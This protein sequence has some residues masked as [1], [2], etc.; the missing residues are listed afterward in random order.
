MTRFNAVPF[1]LDEF[2]A[3]VQVDILQIFVALATADEEHPRAL[4]TALV[5]CEATLHD[6]LREHTKVAGVRLNV[7]AEELASGRVFGV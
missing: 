4:L 6:S 1:F 5:E 3:F 2:E 7:V